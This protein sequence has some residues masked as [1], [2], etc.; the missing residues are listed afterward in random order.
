[1]LMPSVL[2]NS[3]SL[4]RWDLSYTRR[5]AAPLTCKSCHISDSPMTGESAT[6]AVAGCTKVRV[7]DGDRLRLRLWIRYQEIKFKVV[8]LPSPKN[9]PTE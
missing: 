5:I 1:M 7:S 6:K 3:I 4:S 9:R 2:S 8:I